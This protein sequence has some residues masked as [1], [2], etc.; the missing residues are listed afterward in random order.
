ME[1][2]PFLSESD[3]ARAQFALAALRRHNIAPMALTGGMAIELQTL[4]LGLPPQSRPLNDID[5]LVS[6]FDAIPKTLSADFLFR[7]VHPHDPPGKTLLQSVHPESGVRIDIFRA[8]G[9]TVARAEQVEVC[10]HD[11]RIISLHDLTART[12]RL[13]MNLAF[14]ELLSPKHARDFMRLLP[15]VDCESMQP[16]WQEHRKPNHPESFAKAADLLRKSI[17]TRMDLQVAPVYSQDV[18][19][20]CVRCASTET[21]ALADAR[22]IQALL[23]YC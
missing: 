13:A 3:A 7:H 21:F 19:A 20:R 2:S 5:F 22:R 9:G 1:L 11:I 17:A 10:G 12:A 16:I 14:G 4:R 6:S 8:Y 23:G 18:D 15:L